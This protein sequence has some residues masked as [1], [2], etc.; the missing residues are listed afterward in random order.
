MLWLMLVRQP[1]SSKPVAFRKWASGTFAVLILVLANATSVHAQTDKATELRFDELY[2]TYGVL[3]LELS[4]KA[5]SLMGKSVRVLGYMAPPLKAEAAFFV[6]IR[7]PASV[8]PFCSSDADWPVDIMVVYPR[9]NGQKLHS[10]T[11]MA[12]TGRLELGSK[13]DRE[14]GFV[15]QVRIVDAEL[16]KLR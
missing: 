6:L 2:S 3:G 8:C 16:Q 14:T 9:Q 13:I 4:P 15:S 1:Q 10:A 12:I 11:P 5:K 7:A